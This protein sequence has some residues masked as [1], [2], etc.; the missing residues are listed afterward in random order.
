MKLRA[1][2]SLAVFVGLALV[3]VSG[4][5]W[6]P[7]RA[8]QQ[9]SIDLRD[10]YDVKIVGAGR[11]AAAGDVNGD[12]VPDVLVSVGGMAQEPTRGRSWVV[13]GRTEPGVIH[14]DDVSRGDGGFVIE[15]DAERDYAA[16]IA[17]V[18]DVS[19]DGLDD[20]VVGAPGADNNGRESSGSAYV[21][22]G[23]TST[24][25]VRLQ[26]FNLGLQVDE[27]YRIDGPHVRSI[28][29]RDIAGA[30][31]IIGDGLDDVLVGAPFAGAT[32]V[33]FGKDDPSPVDLRTFDDGTQ[34]NTGYRVDTPAPSFDT[35]YSVGNA[36]DVNGDGIPDAL[37]GVMREDGSR[38]VVYVVFGKRDLDPVEVT[39]LGSG[40]FRIK[41]TYSG[42]QTGYEVDGA[43]DV[44]GDEFADVVVGAP[45]GLL[46]APGDAYVVFG[47]KGMRSIRLNHLGTDGFRIKGRQESPGELLG[48][49]VAGIG[50]INGD[51]LDDVV[52]GSVQADFF[53]LRDTGAAYV[54]YGKPTRGT[55]YAQNL[56]DKG[57]T[58]KGHRRRGYAGNTVAGPGDINGDGKP[59]VLVA[60]WPW[61]SFV[62]WRR[63]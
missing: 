3:A 11:V 62:V 34:A 18:G 60:A 61:A 26:L 10:E 19:G 44:N 40:G 39:D 29:G 56:G 22:F 42:S 33:V 48:R 37:I 59:D 27:G 7:T 55:V 28:A 12:A 58:I 46:D 2:G 47:K 5:R 25:P 4:P 45:G 57:Y 8:S 17:G 38:G 24:E 20:I 31:D 54:V 35:N 23:K 36:D 6:S 32:Y 15:G 21:V 14:L 50:D 53:D 51:G 52:V 41:G 16:Q 13:F 30:G 63:P 1:T 49:S 9:T 43:G